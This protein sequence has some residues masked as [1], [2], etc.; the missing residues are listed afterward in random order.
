[1]ATYRQTWIFEGNGHGWSESLYFT[2][3]TQDV[4]AAAAAVLPISA[5]RAAL[6][7]TGC[8]LKGTRTSYILSNLGNP[9]KRVTVINKSRISG[10]VG[11]PECEPNVS[12]QVLLS[13]TLKFNK[14]LMFLGGVWNSIFPSGDFYDQNAVGWLSAFNS[15]V[16]S[17]YNPAM[18]WF[19][20]TGGTNATI[21]G[22]TFNPLTGH[23]TFN[24]GA[25]L[26]LPA[27]GTPI[28]VTVDFPLSKSPLDGTYLVVPTADNVVITAQPRPASPFILPGKMRTKGATLVTLAPVSGGAA[29]TVVAQDPV[30]RK[31][32]RP[33]LVSRGKTPVRD[34]W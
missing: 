18:G 17:L 23:T 25:G 31:R 12:L 27:V 29:G 32:G 28:L 24:L 26:S 30:T 21:E 16:S 13:T 10:V 22:Y 1:M 9:V 33:L 14:K 15:W 3:S 34:L 5:K 8:Q 11:K 4:D 7:G 6:L 2:T 20:S 19:T